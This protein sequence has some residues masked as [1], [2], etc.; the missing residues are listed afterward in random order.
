M[1]VSL[2]FDVSSFLMVDN[3]A[4]GRCAEREREI[5]I[6]DFVTYNLD[7]NSGLGS[8]LKV[9]EHVLWIYNGIGKSNP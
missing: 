3:C 8:L 9:F 6:A 2:S 7:W 1:H 5:Y 4:C